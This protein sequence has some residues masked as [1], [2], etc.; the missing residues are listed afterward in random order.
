[1]LKKLLCLSL[2]LNVLIEG[3]VGKCVHVL[4]PFILDANKM[5]S[6]LNLKTLNENYIRW[7]PYSDFILNA[8][9]QP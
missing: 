5:F 6:L 3:D 9:V 7:S 8:R 4:I 1:M 2:S